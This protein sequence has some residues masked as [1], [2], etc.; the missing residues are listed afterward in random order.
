MTS[1][2]ASFNSADLLRNPTVLI[3]VFLITVVMMMV[4][5]VPSFVIDIGL[6]LSFGMAVLMFMIVLFIDRPLDFS[7]FPGVLLASLL[8]R[9]S[10]NVCSTKL[11][12]SHGHSGTGAAGEIIESFARFIM[13]GSLL[14]GTVIFFTILIV[15]FM[16]ITKGAGRMAEVSARFALDAMPGKQLAIDAD[17][18]SGAITHAEAKERRRIEQEETVFYGSLDGASKF[19]KGDAVAGMIITAMNFVVGLCVGVFVHNMPVDQALHTYSILT[20]GDGLVTQ[21]PAVII[22]IASALLTAK[23]GV[24][25]SADVTVI[26]QFFAHPYALRT[27]AVL[28][29]LCALL[30][31]IP[32]LPF[33]AAAG[34]LEYAARK[35]HAD[36]E[37]RHADERANAA[38]ALKTEARPSGQQTLGDHME[39]DDIRVEFSRALLPIITDSLHGVAARITAM[40]RSLAGEMGFIMPEVRL[41][42][43]VTLPDLT[44]LIKIHGVKAAQAKLKANSILLIKRDGVAVPFAG[45]DTEE[46]VY[47]APARWISDSQRDDAVLSGFSTATHN[48]II[49]THLMESIKCNMRELVTRQAMQRMLDEFMNVSDTVRAAGNRKMLEEMIPDQVPREILQHVLRAL[50]EERISVR[51]IPLILEAIAETRAQ[52]NNDPILIGEMVRRKLSFQISSGFVD[53][54]GQLPLIRLSSDWEKVFK[55]H[56][57]TDHNGRVVDVALPPSETAALADRLL[58]RIVE[59]SQNG[60][61]AAIVTASS[62]RRMIRNLLESRNLRNP[63]L[64]FEEVHPR[65]KAS[66]LSTV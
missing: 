57:V 11:I 4:V 59:A 30:P 61:Y 33:L 22:S 2:A 63:V 35:A 56:E 20:I 19:V 38:A 9:L 29:G 49:A 37:K 58:G 53:A 21:I 66:V 24:R 3:A 39:V 26:K 17:V 10:L 8:L 32:K 16:V 60:I 41:T 1:A 55:P 46:P 13:G 6:T 36:V 18:S 14:T 48:E 64:A 52:N 5:P 42:D 44:Y 50:L 25:G 43:N 51:N 23:G 47:N 54:N 45:E 28:A 15:N 31:G 40:R 65:I 7:A 12:I 27:V 34:L 62:R